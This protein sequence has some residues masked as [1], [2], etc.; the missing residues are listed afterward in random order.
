MT[1]QNDSG[2]SDF[3]SSSHLN[4][5][6]SVLVTSNKNSFIQLFVDFPDRISFK[7]YSDLIIRALFVMKKAKPIQ[8]YVLPLDYNNLHMPP[9]DM[10]YI[11][12]SLPV[13][14]AALWSL[15]SKGRVQGVSC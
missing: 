10:F 9:T 7:D 3:I 6:Y 2:L 5:Y 14:S 4:F 15:V 13:F 11:T 1:V 8:R 12:S